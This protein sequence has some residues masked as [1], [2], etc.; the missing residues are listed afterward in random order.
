[1]ST[2]TNPAFCTELQM[3]MARFVLLQ[4]LG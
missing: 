2:F 3:H 1:M 4:S